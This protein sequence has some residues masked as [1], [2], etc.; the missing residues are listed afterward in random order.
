MKQQRVYN[1]TNRFTVSDSDTKPVWRNSSVGII[2]S[3]FQIKTRFMGVVVESGARIHGV[4][5]TGRP[6]HEDVG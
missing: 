3:I 2:A 6:A 4:K 1:P 5:G